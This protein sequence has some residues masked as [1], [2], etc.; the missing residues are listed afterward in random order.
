MTEELKIIINKLEHEIQLVQETGEQDE[1]MENVNEIRDELERT[2]NNFDAIESILELIER[3]PD[4]DYGG[5]GPIAHFM[6]SH[7]K[8][9]YEELLLKSI[10]RKPTEYTLYLLHRLI[11]DGANPN[12]IVYLDLMKKISLSEEY[13]QNIIL[14]AKESLAD[15]Q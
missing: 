10:D 6:E 1:F 9:G 8:K 7:Y 12:R 5:P 11:N 15:F 4:I 13:P 3:S 14:N 2:E